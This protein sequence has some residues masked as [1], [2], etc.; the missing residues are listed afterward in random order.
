MNPT[1]T[2]IRRAK[3]SLVILSAGIA[4]TTFS[5]LYHHSKTDG[6]VASRLNQVEN[7]PRKSEQR[8]PDAQRD[9]D[10]DTSGETWSEVEAMHAADAHTVKRWK[11]AAIRRVEK[12]DQELKLSYSQHHRILEQVMAFSAPEGV[13]LRIGDRAV[14]GAELAPQAQSLEDAIADALDP[15]RA[16][17]YQQSL[18]DHAAWWEHAIEQMESSAAED[19]PS[20][21]EAVMDDA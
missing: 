5:F 9:Q 1:I 17:L 7:P 12:L 19:E 8:S 10:R 3:K 20:A 13:T 6:D 15:E 16:R 2:M 14:D 21:T 11:M 18:M 4:M